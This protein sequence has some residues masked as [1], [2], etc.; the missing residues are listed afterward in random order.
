MILPVSD[1]QTADLRC[2][3]GNLENVHG[4]RPVHLILVNIT[5]MSADLLRHAFSGQEKIKVVGSASTSSELATLLKEQ[6]PDVALLGS[7][8]SR[9]ESGALPFLEQI[10]ATG[11]VVRPIILSEDMSR[12]DVVT[13]FRK[14]ARG[15]LCKSQSDV[16]VLMKC[17]D[18]VAAGQVWANA[19]QM[20]ILLRSLSHPRSLT[21]TNVMGDAL[22]SQREEQVLDLLARGLS[23]RDLAR[24]LKLS[25][26]TV[27]NHLFRIFDKLGVSNRME[28]VLYA[29]NNSKQKAMPSRAAASPEVETGAA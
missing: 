15:L 29:M 23:N 13:F 9:Q 10:A 8:G 2:F 21:V 20:E 27:K 6:F 7:N 18:C 14:G 3:M 26:H 11:T 17:L 12:E 16:S 1:A 4:N 5:A 19:E 24:E 28:A 25:E 22:L